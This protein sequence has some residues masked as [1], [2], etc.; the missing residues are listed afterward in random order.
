MYNRNVE[1]YILF[2]NRLPLTKEQKKEFVKYH[3]EILKKQ[4]EEE[5]ENR[6]YFSNEVLPSI[7]A[8]N[9]ELPL[10]QPVLRRS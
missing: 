6:A 9:E 10:I 7:R 2:V 5:K 8:Y 4:K 3:M 1:E